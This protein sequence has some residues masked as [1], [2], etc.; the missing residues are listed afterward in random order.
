MDQVFVQNTKQSI[1]RER[2]GKD[3]VHTGLQIRVDIL[4]QSVRS[5][6]ILSRSRTGLDIGGHRDNWGVDVELS[7]QAGGFA[8]AVSSVQ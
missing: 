3:I 5:L 7:D 4:C 8:T 2:F 1:L 6:T